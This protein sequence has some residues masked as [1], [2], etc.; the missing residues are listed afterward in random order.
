MTL[1]DP[2][3]NLRENQAVEIS[4]NIKWAAKSFMFS[5]CIFRVVQL[6]ILLTSRI[7]FI[8]SSP[9]VY[10]NF[11]VSRPCTL[12]KQKINNIHKNLPIL[13]QLFQGLAT[14]FINDNQ[15]T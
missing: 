1:K 11:F 7:Q 3:S 15:F 8:K 12:E 9:F 5:L 14:W 6:V 10:P 13:R 2:F 4:R